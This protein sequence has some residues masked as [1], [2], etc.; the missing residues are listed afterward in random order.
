MAKRKLSPAQLEALRRGRAKL[1]G[2]RQ[3][4][5]RARKPNPLKAGYS[6]R[7]VSANVSELVRSG[8]TQGQATRIALDSARKSYRAK[9][10]RGAFPSHI[11]KTRTPRRRNPAGPPTRGAVRGSQIKGMRQGAAR[12]LVT[13]QEIG[14]K[15]LQRYPQAG[16]KTLGYRSNPPHYVIKC[17]GKGYFDG[18]GFSS[19]KKGAAQYMTKQKAATIGQMVADRTGKQCAVVPV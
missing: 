15:H 1:A 2:K 17:D 14:T 3:R 4:T 11:A 19:T 18:A 6:T 12:R 9:H 5:K 16:Q 10:P 8:R 7:T 13:Q